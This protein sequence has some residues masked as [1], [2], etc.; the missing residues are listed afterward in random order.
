MGIFI[1]LFSEM[2]RDLFVTINHRAECVIGKAGFSGPPLK[3]AK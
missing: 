1:H 2:H 3:K